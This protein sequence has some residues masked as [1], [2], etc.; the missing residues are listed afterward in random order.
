VLDLADAHLAALELTASM[1]PGQAVCNLGSGGGFSGRQVLD[2]ASPTVGRPIP[3][4]YGP[5]RAGDPPVLVASGD[6]ARTLLAW[7]PAR[8]S[9]A[10]MIGSAWR[11]MEQDRS[12]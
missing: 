10:E 7:E 4:R 9:L 1:E 11:I 2:S 6:R 5:R 8:G 12:R 3:H